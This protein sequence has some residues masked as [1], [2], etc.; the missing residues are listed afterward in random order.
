LV[1]CPNPD[2]NC[3]FFGS[4]KA[5]NYVV[6]VFLTISVKVRH[7]LIGR[8]YNISIIKG[9]SIIFNWSDIGSRVNGGLRG[10]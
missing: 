5:S 3:I 8:P 2:I 6:E 4:P 10:L 9:E 1:R 7:I